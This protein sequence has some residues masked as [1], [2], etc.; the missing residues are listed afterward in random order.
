MYVYIC[1][2]YNE[3]PRYYLSIEIKDHKFWRFKT[4]LYNCHSS[5]PE[6]IPV[7]MLHVR[8][9]IPFMRF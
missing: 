1:S 9:Y 5:K 8:M 3:F 4:H 7:Y 2:V 6:H